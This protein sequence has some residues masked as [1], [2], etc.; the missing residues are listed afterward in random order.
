ML[1]SS[2]ADHSI[3]SDSWH[4]GG[5]SV[6]KWI[7]IIS[8]TGVRTDKEKKTFET[9]SHRR[10]GAGSPPGVKNEMEV[11]SIKMRFSQ[12]AG[13]KGDN[14]TERQDEHREMRVVCVSK[15]HHRRSSW[16][17]SNTICFSVLLMVL[18]FAAVVWE[19]EKFNE[20]AGRGRV[21]RRCL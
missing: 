1:P 17:S 3:K 18:K 21:V 8:S 11:T 19:M 12:R 16:W 10:C 9:S 20:R 2:K 14:R 13:S 4:R 15:V 6:A 7:C 5:A